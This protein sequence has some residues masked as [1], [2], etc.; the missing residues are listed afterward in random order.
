[1]KTTQYQFLSITLKSML[2]LFSVID[3]QQKHI[4]ED[5]A[6]IRLSG[7]EWMVSRCAKLVE[8]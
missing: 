5:K 8:I 4:K 7:R 1:M 3:R 2:K 6:L